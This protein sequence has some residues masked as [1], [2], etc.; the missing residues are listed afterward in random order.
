MR[1]RAVIE[2]GDV[3]AAYPDDQPF[4]SYLMLGWS[5]ERPLHVVVAVDA[6]ASRCYVVTAY[7]PDPALWHADFKTRREP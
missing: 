2:T 4:P 6:T 5:G 7:P 3:V 1:L